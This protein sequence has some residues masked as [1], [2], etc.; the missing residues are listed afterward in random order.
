MTDIAGDIQYKE[1]A[2]R[3]GI[4]KSNV[5]RWS[6]GSKPAV[7]FV[8]KFARSYGQPVVA[9]LAAAGY[10]TDTEAQVREVKIGVEE[11]SDIDLARE[12]LRRIEGRGAAPSNVTPLRGPNVGATMQDLAEV[13]F[14]SDID[15]SQDTDDYNA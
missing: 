2:D 4:D 7:E 9:A 12:L 13:A 6:K 10:I 5:T 14:E 3:V 15:H 8:L 1:I 11:I